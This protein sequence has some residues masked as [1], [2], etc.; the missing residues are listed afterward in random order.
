MRRTFG[1]WTLLLTF[2]AAA[3]AGV[4]G[5]HTLGDQAAALGH[6]SM[7]TSVAQSATA[8]SPFHVSAVEDAFD[9]VDVAGTDSVLACEL[10]ALLSA[11]TVFVLLLQARGPLAMFFTPAS[12]GAEG[13]R[14]PAGGISAWPVSLTVLGIS[15]I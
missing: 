7:V 6:Q 15:R 9:A 1:L 2:T 14:F 11:A 3:L 10:L 13:F 5:V 12:T 4:L 8:A